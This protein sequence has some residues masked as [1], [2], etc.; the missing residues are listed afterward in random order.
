MIALDNG[1][2]QPLDPSEVASFGPRFR[3]RFVETRSKSPAAAIN[4]AAREA[5]GEELVVMIDGAHIITPRVLQ[6]MRRAFDQFESPFVATPPFHLGPKIQNQSVLE[7]YNQPFIGQVPV[8]ALPAAAAS[9]AH[10]LRFWQQQG[11]SQPDLFAPT[12]ASRH[13]R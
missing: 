6:G 10:G 9:A 5:S 3:H 13:S 1:S 11:P 12:P 4:A 7:G 2:T 8:Q